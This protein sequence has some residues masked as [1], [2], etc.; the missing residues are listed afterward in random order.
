MTHKW[1]IEPHPDTTDFD[2][3]DCDT[4]D[5]AREALLRAA[6]MIFDAMEPGD[7]RTITIRLL[8]VQDPQ[9]GSP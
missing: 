5:E 8:A 9:G 4:D 6:E 7:T 1:E 2:V 3:C